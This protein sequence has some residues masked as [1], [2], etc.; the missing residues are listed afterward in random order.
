MMEGWYQ[1]NKDR[2]QAKAK[3]WEEAE[4]S[5]IN[6]TGCEAPATKEVLDSYSLARV[7]ADDWRESKFT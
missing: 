4:R 2:S 7:K 1:P 3:R 6:D 5:G